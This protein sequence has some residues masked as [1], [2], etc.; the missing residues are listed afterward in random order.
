MLSHFYDL[1][2]WNIT[3]EIHPIAHL[4]IQASHADFFDFSTMHKT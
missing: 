3:S 2:H 1:K 4:E